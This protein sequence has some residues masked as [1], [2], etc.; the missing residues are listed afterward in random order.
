MKPSA[1]PA[2]M[3]GGAKDLFIDMVKR[4]ESPLTA[5][6]LLGL[7]LLI[8]Y[9]KQIPVRFR[10]LADTLL[11]RLLLFILTI[12]VAKYTTFS[13]GLL[14]ALFT[15]LLLSMSPRTIE[16]YQDVRSSKKIT[17]NNLWWVEKVFNEHPK[18][19]DEDEVTTSAIQDGSTNQKSGSSSSGGP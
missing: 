19:I 9:V 6:T 14:L 2:I 13:N 5:Y 18:E 7:A 16:G 1:P 12:L 17:D 8:V 4:H 10:R 15:L 11:G 3:T